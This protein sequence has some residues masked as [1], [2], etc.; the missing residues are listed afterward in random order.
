MPDTPLFEPYRFTSAGPHR[1][2]TPITTDDWLTPTSAPEPVA[3]VARQVLACVRTA[4][5]CTVAQAAASC[6]LPEGV[7]LVAVTDL[8]R[9]GLVRITPA[10]EG[11]VR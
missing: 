3:P 1:S 9:A 2:R 8:E 4:E 11:G 6:D 7:A 10:E 5:D